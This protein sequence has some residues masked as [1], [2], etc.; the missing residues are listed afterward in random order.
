[1]ISH[2]ERLE[3]CLAGHKLDRPPVALW[4]HFPVDDQTPEGLASATINFQRT[5]DFD[6]V[7]VTPASSFCLKDWGVQDTWKGSTEGTRDYTKFVIHEPEDWLKLTELDP[8]KGHLGDQLKCLELITNDLGSEIPVIQTIFNPLSQ[9]KN[10]IGK[11]ELITHLRKYPSALHS[12]LQTITKTTRAFIEAATKTG[13]SGLFFA[14]QHASYDLL[15]SGEYREFGTQYDLYLLEQL[16]S[17]WFNVLHIHGNNIMFDELVNYPVEVINWHDQE[18][19]PSLD[20]AKTIFSG[21]VCGGISRE[22]TIVLGTPTDLID[23]ASC[24]F[25]KTGKQRFILGTGCV[26][27]VTAPFGNLLAV[28]ES[29]N[30]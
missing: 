10:L 21:V 17:L 13:I 23:E 20:Y 14:T 29:V 7:K 15:N 25:E 11:D 19:Y 9:A 2:R 12:G 24:A 4:R 26:V 3:A 16:E 28:R 22:E 1:M 6:F 5:F 27:P 30:Q 18:T 8:H